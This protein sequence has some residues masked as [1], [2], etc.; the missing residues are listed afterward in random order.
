MKPFLNDIPVALI[1][2]TRPDL[3][4]ITFAA[5]KEA[6]PSKLFLIQDGQRIDNSS[7]LSNIYKCRDIVEKIDWDCKVYKNYSEENL[8][9]GMRIFS[10]L[11]WAFKY[12]DH[13]LIIEDDCVPSQSLFPFTL[14][15]L[16][17]YKYD[18]RIGMICGMNNLESCLN[19]PNDY[20]FSTS[21]SIWGWAT[22]K[23][24]WQKVEYDLDFL[25]DDY[26]TNT[27]YKT[28]MRLKSMG[29]INIKKIKRGEKLTSWS[30][31]FGM[32]IFLQHQLNIIPK[33]NMIE[34]IGL[35]ENGANSVS[36]IKFIPRGLRS[37]YNMKTY[38]YDFPLKHPKYVVNDLEFKAKVDRLMGNGHKFIS[39][40]R[41]LESIIYRIIAGDFNSIK[42]GIVRRFG[43]QN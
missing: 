39:L 9:C 10:G 38:S 37:L 16:D 11:N 18:D 28:D 34:N 4:E 14:E 20:F 13:L 19:L 32:N 41:K 2:F 35:S 30:Y 33:Y 24:V 5:I 12:V 36:S 1:F 21:G 23:R 25:E 26:S 8:G 29:E 15:L 3:L 17:K 31:Q 22:W 6:R 27:V 42:K 7:D 40:Y 43:K